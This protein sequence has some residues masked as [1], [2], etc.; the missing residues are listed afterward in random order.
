MVEADA[1]TP[2]PAVTDLPDHSRRRFLHA[3]AASLVALAL[4]PSAARGAALAPRRLRLR[5][6]HTGERL[7]VTYF[8][9]G[10]LPG[11]MGELDRFLRDFRTGEQHPIDPGVLDVAWGLGQA[12]GRADGEMEIVSGY[13]SRRTNEMLRG[14]VD[15]GVASHSLHLVGRA[16]DLRLPGVPTRHLRDLAVAMGRGGVGFYAASDF[17]HVD[18]GRPRRW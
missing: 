18:T 14:R 2:A 1:A 4:G 13:R 3:G 6:A 12:A 7:D 5:N 9:G 15:S 16:L 11:P 8:D 17:L 10:L